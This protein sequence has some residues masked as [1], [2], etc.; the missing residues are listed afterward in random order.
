MTDN[1][2]GAA[3]SA[4]EDKLSVNLPYVLLYTI[5]QGPCVWHT[6]W[7]L[8]GNS[9]TTDVFRAKFGWN[10]DDTLFY[11]TI[12]SS[13][14]IVGLMIGSFLGGWLMKAGR[15]RAAMIAQT[16]AIVSSL[17]T[18]AGTVAF[19]TIGRVLLGIAAGSM[20]VILAKLITENMPERYA[21]MLSI[22]VNASI[23]TGL[24]PCYLLGAVLPDPDDFQANFDDELWRVIFLTPAVVA[25]LELC[26][27]FT[28]FRYEPI[29]FCIVNN[30]DDQAILHMKK[31]YRLADAA[32]SPRSGDISASI[33]EILS[34][35][36]K[37]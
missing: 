31:V 37:L 3:A 10:D 33:D 16:L 32:L 22:F 27:M 24:I 20:N 11:N 2:V 4:A 18:M 35:Q 13:A 21:A 9:Q 36:C 15:R 19:L 1:A 29:N 28:L 8:A 5:L 23:A 26:F 7:A 12:I 34:A 17:V 6:S 14:G 25:A 30:L